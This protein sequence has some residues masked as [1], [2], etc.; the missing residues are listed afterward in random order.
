MKIVLADYGGYPFTYQLAGSLVDRGHDVLYAYRDSSRLRDVA[1][2]RAKPDGTGA[3]VRAVWLDRGERMEKGNLLVRWV[4]ERGFGRR[5]ARQLGSERP[6]VVLSANMPL[7]AQSAVTAKARLLDIPIVYWLQDLIGTATGAILTERLGLAGSILGSYYVSLE[8]RL[9]RRS[10]KVIAISE[11]FRDSLDGRGVRHEQLVVHPNW[12]PIDEIPVHPKD[13]EWARAH[14]WNQRPIILY[15]GSLGMKHDPEL[16]AN[17]ARSLQAGGDTQVVVVA[18]GAGATWLA[19]HVES[20]SLRN[21]H[22]LPFQDRS[23]LSQVLATADVLVAMLEP[24][25]GT[26]SVPSKVLSYLCAGRPIVAAVPASNDVARLL[27]RTGAGMTSSPGDGPA[28]AGTVKLLLE[29][30]ARRAVM[31]D[32][33]RRFA[34]EAFDIDA[35]TSRFEGFLRDVVTT[36]DE[37]GVDP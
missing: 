28:L 14:G 31:G 1:T 33:A 3:P 32:A 16:L 29:D 11:A 6:D 2:P 5:L 27:E 19:E 37:E 12:S 7:D 4:Q 34:E 25:A 22:V 9:L 36:G 13:N 35:I 18:E 23:V 30:G 15:S 17:L 21:L 24:S 8:N 10:D 20:D 26:Y